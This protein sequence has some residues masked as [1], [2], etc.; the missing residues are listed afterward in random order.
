MNKVE[1]LIAEVSTA[2]NN[3]LQQLSFFSE[4]KAKWK[5]TAEIWCATEITEHLFWAEQGAII[6]MWKTLYTIREGKMER[7]YDSVHKEMPVEKIIELT[8]KDKEIVPAVA[9]PRVGGPLSFWYA[10]LS[11]LQQVLETFGNDLKENELRI[12]A[13]PHP[14]SGP[15]DFQQ[16]LEFLRLHLNRHEAQVAALMEEI[17]HS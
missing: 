6:G 14:I 10:S 12:L 2:R 8:W 3:F 13:H 15:M 9:A 11:S 1:N 5:P 4:E 7:T 16:R 17:K